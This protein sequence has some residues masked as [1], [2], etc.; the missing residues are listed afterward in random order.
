MGTLVGTDGADHLQ[1]T[2]TDPVLDGLGGND[3]LFG[4]AQD[5]T[6]YG[7]P[8]DDTLAGGYVGGY[9]RVNPTDPLVYVEHVGIDAVFG[10]DGNDRI[11]LVGDYRSTL[12]GGAGEDTLYVSLLDASDTIDLS[13]GAL[14]HGETVGGVAQ[15]ELRY[16]L[17][18][19]EDVLLDGGAAVGDDGPNHLE[20]IA[21]PYAYASYLP[22]S[23]V[24][25]DG[26]GG[27]DTL[28][29]TGGGDLLS[30]GSGDD[31]INPVFGTDT[32]Y[33]GSGDDLLYAGASGGV[34]E[35]GIGDD[36]LSF[37]GIN[38]AVTASLEDGLAGSTFTFLTLSG[39]E[40]LVGGALGDRLTGDAGNNFIDGGFGD[41][42]LA[43]MGGSDTLEGGVGQDVAVFS[44]GIDAYTVTSIAG[45]VSVRGPEGTA[46]LSDVE[47]IVFADAAL[48][49]TPVVGSGIPDYLV[50]TAD[51]ET[52]QGAGGDDTI[53][54]SGG[55]DV[56]DGGSGDDLVRFAGFAHD[57]RFSLQ[58]ATGS[59]SGG[60]EAAHDALS[61][62]ES[63][64]F[65]DGV[66]TFDPASTAAQIV[67]L[68]DSF[69]GR[70]PDA[71][72]F[73][74][75]LNYVAQGHSFQDMANNAAASPEFA[76]ATAGLTD[77]QYIT[78]VYEH[79]LHREPDAYGLQQYE[80]ALHD[81]T[82]T[83]T[84]MIV[85]AA[86]SPE[87]VALTAS[88]VAQGLWI[89][90]AHV[91]GLELLYDA[92]VQRQPDPTGI[93]GYSAELSSGE[94]FRQI[95]DQ[96]AA[97]AEFQAAHAGQ[98][99]AQYVD[100]LY[101]AEVGR[102]ADPTGLAAYTAEL[103]NG[104]SRGDILYET[105]MSQEHQSHVLAFYDPLLIG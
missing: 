97:S 21:D 27:D 105:A 58:G 14:V 1:T 52:I 68:Y 81:G 20:G 82:L 9:L 16:H 57:Y 8:G 98:S 55:H 5:D 26:A 7:G 76:N 93:A 36:T 75:Y 67:R 88:I 87:H 41:D 49:L 25:L 32:V 35:G 72:G 22:T 80:Q 74:S 65:L 83:R 89:P 78:Y 10:G 24:T 46:T 71:A 12:D 103:V 6:L 2:V 34:F 28:D 77:D 101:V 47:R 64:Q 70:A 86:E 94:T 18:G 11:T 85:Q 104:H 69:L 99:D 59:V 92:A 79:S 23:A 40:N 19:I 102:H 29:G 53:V 43:G 60:V 33:G 30:G 91:E 96:M 56:L 39:I 31:V 17:V 61:S 50:G 66:L 54:A 4:A 45:G 73:D 63:V 100:S 48:S 37:A 84:S 15:T 90:D 62:I 42:T 13:Q 44:G 38:N 3:S 95:A 51:G